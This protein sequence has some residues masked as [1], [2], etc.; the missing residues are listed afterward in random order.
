VKAV[1]ASTSNYPSAESSATTFSIT[2]RPITVTIDSVSSQYGDSIAT[3]T[4]NVTTGSIVNGDTNVYSLSTTATSSSG[5]GYYP[6]TGTS[7]NS[8]YNVTF[9]NGGQDLYEILQRAISVT[10]DAKESVYGEEIVALTASITS[11]S[12]VGGDTNLWLLHTS[13]TNSSSVGQYAI[14]GETKNSNYSI[15]FTNGNDLLYTIKKRTARISVGTLKVT[16]G[17][18][19]PQESYKISGLASCDTED[20][21]GNITLSCN[22][23]PI[24]SKAGTACPVTISTEKTSENYNLQL[25]KGS[26]IV[27]PREI[28]V[29]IQPATSVYGDHIAKLTGKVTSGKVLDGDSAYSLYTRARSSSNAG[30]YDVFGMATNTNYKVTFTNGTGAYTITKRALTITALDTKVQY[31]DEQAMFNYKVEGLALNDFVTHICGE[32]TY[33]CD[34]TKTSPY[35]STFTITP[36][37]KTTSDNYDIT[38]VTGTLS[39]VKREITVYIDKVSSVYGGEISSLTATVVAGSIVNGDTNVYTLKTTATSTSSVGYYDITG[40][41]NGSYNVT[42]EHGEDAYEVT[43]RTLTITATDTT[44]SIDD[45]PEYQYT[46]DGLVNNDTVE[47]VCGDITFTCNRTIYTGTYAIMPSGNE[48]A[49]NYV[50]VYKQGWLTVTD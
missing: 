19:L 10:I 13:A 28:T 11:G 48:S 7:N 32:I 26:V 50:I 39:V 5:V 15:K 33:N 43:P 42:F 46:V 34:Y 25:I 16:Y 44:V 29:E 9:A 2:V 1:V 47:S 21:F 6:I 4:G 40:S 12:P 14:W 20:I 36:V 31:G 22:Y 23:T 8:N 17:D 49:K 30:T 41:S 24:T 27:V 38:Y 45:E 3:L 37:G 18:E 35:G